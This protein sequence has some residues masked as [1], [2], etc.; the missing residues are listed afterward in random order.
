VELRMP[1]RERGPWR[2]SVLWSERRNEKKFGASRDE[3]KASEDA[4]E[5]AAESYIWQVGPTDL[6]TPTVRSNTSYYNQPQDDQRDK[7]ARDGALRN[8][9]RAYDHAGCAVPP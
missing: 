1:R 8:P 7:R 5:R 9:R 3:R 6:Q 2:R 4:L